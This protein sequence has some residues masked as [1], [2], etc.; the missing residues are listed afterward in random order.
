MG[1]Q[2]DHRSLSTGLEMDTVFSARRTIKVEVAN[3]FE[4][5]HSMNKCFHVM[6]GIIKQVLIS[7]GWKVC[8]GRERER[9]MCY[10]YNQ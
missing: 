4:H 2:T 7:E 3:T 6:P 8:V 1:G 9:E 5:T 10:N